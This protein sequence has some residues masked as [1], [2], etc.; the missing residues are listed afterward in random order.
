MYFKFLEI[1]ELSGE[2]LQLLLVEVAAFF[3]GQ[4]VHSCS[5]SL[6]N[7]ILILT[8]IKIINFP[9]LISGPSLQLDTLFTHY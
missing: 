7:A 9:A 4:K 1:Q 8:L 3:V 5:H 6:G 2:G